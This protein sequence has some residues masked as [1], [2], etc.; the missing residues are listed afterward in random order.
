MGLAVIGKEPLQLLKPV[1]TPFIRLLIIDYDQSVDVL[2]AFADE[3][4]NL[5]KERDVEYA[6]LNISVEQSALIAYFKQI[7][8]EELANRYQ[9]SRPIDEAVEVS[10]LLR[11]EQIQRKDVNRFFECMKEFMSGSPDIVMNM[12][13]ENFKNVPEELLDVWYESVQAYFVYHNEELIGILDLVPPNSFIQNIGVSP[14]HRGKG[15]G[16]EM[17]RFCLKLFKDAGGKAAGLGV[18]VD[19]KRAIQVYEKLGFAVAKQIETLVWW[20]PS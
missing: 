9:M 12:V 1:G 3:V 7:G 18:H 17:L 6:Q 16:M 19:N 14:K 4:L 8:F 15:F 5:A 11:F 13:I 20:K 10:D 2:N